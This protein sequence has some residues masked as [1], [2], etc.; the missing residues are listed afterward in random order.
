M[1]EFVK[2]AKVDDIPP[3]EMAGFVVNHV[4]VGVANIGGEFF[5]FHNCCTHQQY[6]LTDG[7]LMGE[8]LTCDWHGATFDIR[9]GEVK[10]LPAT[11]PLPMFEVEVR[12]G[13][14]WV[15]VP[16]ADDLDMPPE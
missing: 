2:L 10:T 9:T 4:K 13:E 11:K 5:A 7:F 3:D 15:A 6:E 8:R 1:A 16:D 14:V 12:D